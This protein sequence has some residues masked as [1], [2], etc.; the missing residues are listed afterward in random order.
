[1]RKTLMYGIA[2]AVAVPATATAAK[3]PKP[4]KPYGVC[5][6]KAVGYHATGT[7]ES[8]TLTQTAGADTAKRGDDRYSGDVVVTVKKAN[9]KG[10]KGEQT[11]TLTNARVKFHPRKDTSVAA[12]DRIKLAGKVTKLAKKCDATG[13][14]PTL[15]ARK[16]DIKA[17]RS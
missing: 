3:P 8:G 11:F 7:Y 10:L 12:G 9:H 15:T 17:K 13:F 4:T 1:M 14:E 2:I 16:A 5:T 6:P